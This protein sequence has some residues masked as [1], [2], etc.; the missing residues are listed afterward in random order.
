MRRRSLFLL[1]GVTLLWP[2]LVAAL[3]EVVHEGCQPDCSCKGKTCGCNDGF[4]KGLEGSCLP[5]PC[6]EPIIVHGEDLSSCAGTHAGETCEFRCAFGYKPKG[7]LRC[8]HGGGWG[9][10]AVCAVEQAVKGVVK[11][12]L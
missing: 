3:S 2:R 5:C 7:T 8:L 10:G 9:K 1:A 12:E 6:R 11:E 4:C